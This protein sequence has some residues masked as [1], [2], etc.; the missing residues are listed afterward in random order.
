[1]EATQRNGDVNDAEQSRLRMLTLRTGYSMAWD[2]STHQYDGGATN[3]NEDDWYG[4]QALAGEP[5]NTK[6]ACQIK[7]YLCA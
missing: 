6:Q 1:M 4:R 5:Y 3:G 2:Q 7:E